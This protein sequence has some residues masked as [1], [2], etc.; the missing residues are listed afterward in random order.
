MNQD[1][2]LYHTIIPEDSDG[3]YNTVND[4]DCDTEEYGIRFC[5]N[6]YFRLTHLPLK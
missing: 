5:G 3:S 4:S 1:E 2:G 6:R